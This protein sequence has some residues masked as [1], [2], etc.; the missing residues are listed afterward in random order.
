MTAKSLSLRVR[1]ALCLGLTAFLLTAPLT[2][3]AQGTSTITGVV[4]SQAGRPVSDATISFDSAANVQTDGN[5]RFRLTI[6]AG[7]GG[8]LSI[9][10]VGFAPAKLELSAITSA[11]TRSVAITLAPIIVVDA[12]TV[13]GSADRPLLNTEDA[14]TGGAVEAAEIQAL[15]TDARDPVAL[16]A[17]VP[18]VAQSSGF[19]G[20]APILTFNALNGLYTSYTLDGLDN[21]EGFLG[22]PRVEFPLGGLAREEALVN[23]YPTRYGRSPSGVVALESRAGT[24]ETRGDAF[25]FY[26][27]G[28]PFDARTKTPFG[29]AADS[30]AILDRQQDGF[31]RYHLGSGISGALDPGRTFYAAAAEYSDENEDRVSSTARTAFVGTERRQKVKLFGRIDHGW[32][33]TQ[34]TT[35]R[36]A[37]SWVDRAGR[38]GGVVTPEADVTT[39]RIGTLTALIHRSALR[40]GSGGNTAAFQVGTFRWYFPPTLS[41]LRVPQ[42]TILD[43]ATGATLAVVGSSNFV[44]DESETQLQLRDVFERR[45]GDHATA[46]GGEIIRSSFQLTGSNTNPNGAYAVFNDPGTPIP[47]AGELYT[48]AEIP[49]GVRVASYTIDANP[50]QVDLTQGLYSAFIEDKWRVTPSLL[51]TTGV[52]W[53]YDDLTSRGGSSAD[54]NNFQPRFSFNWYATPG[55]VIRGGAGMYA[56]KFPYAIYSDA[57]QFGPGGNATVTFDSTTTPGAPTFRQGLTPE[58]LATQQSL[59][60]AREQRRMFAHG[61]EQPMSYQAT[62]GTQF[63]VGERWAVTVDA[64]FSE[65]RHL[66]RSYD[67]NAGGYALTSGDTSG[68]ANKPVSF[69]D[70]LRPVTPTTGGYRRLTTTESAGLSRYWGVY[71]SVR[72]QMS[73]AWSLDANWV[74]SRARNNTED[75]NFNAA[76]GNDFAAEWADASNDRRHRVTLRSVYTL[77]EAL[78]L[79]VIGDYQTGLP[80]NRVAG[81]LNA[82]GSV[83]TYDLD[84]S[85]SSFG[86]GFIGNNDRYFGVPRNGER[87]PNFL[88]LST[89]AAYIWHTRAGDLEFRADVFNLL[90]GTQWGNFANGIPGGGSRTQYGHP[91][92]PI[93]LRSPGPPRQ[94]QLS[95]RFVF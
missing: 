73:D 6:P 63:L 43:S 56:G 15:P 75:I 36:A 29:T 49:D 13:V 37:M 45:S 82:D 51:L 90:N 4:R 16:L 88:A 85:G 46:V 42:V 23:T 31:R 25:A 92:D 18:G 65:T 50:A 1:L 34:T 5:G 41:S 54:L 79:S 62:L 24:P 35:L 7:V 84:G 71:L 12:I 47:R 76:V 55:V 91:G 83:V 8:R 61:L 70:T 30:R 68:A 59:L 72:R 52:R 10:A 3:H 60:P 39:R 21:T 69:G 11:A 22:G 17:N 89:S 27:P 44:F 95:T 58:E 32:S 81:T 26:R 2:A 20:D 9:R 86:D 64:V 93:V 80:V 78:R 48:Y 67:L 94:I 19:F 77:A 40:D 28:R 66:P 33:P 38:G 74:W 53:D 57:V 14:T 87:L